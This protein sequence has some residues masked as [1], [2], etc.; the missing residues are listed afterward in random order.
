MGHSVFG[1]N[2]AKCWLIFK[3]FSLLDRGWN[4]QLNLYENFHHTLYVLLH[5][6]VK[7][8]HLR[9]VIDI[10]AEFAEKYAPLTCLYT[11]SQVRVPLV[12]CWKSSLFF[13]RT[14]LS[15]TAR[16]TVWFL[17]QVTLQFISPDHT[18]P[19]L[20]Q[21]TTVFVVLPNSSTVS[22]DLYWCGHQGRFPGDEVT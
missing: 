11:R 10:V 14:A 7:L 18:A 8:T 3:I 21:W 4:F 6:F 1:N 13:S 12:N 22:T 19:T 2:F 9:S 16:N 20:T 17:T 15:H 5:Y